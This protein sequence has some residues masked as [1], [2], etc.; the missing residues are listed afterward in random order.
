MPDTEYPMEIVAEFTTNH[1]GHTG[2]LMNMVHE[3]KKAGATRIKLQFKNVETYYTEHKLNSPIRSPF[4]DTYKEHRS[5]FELSDYQVDLVK[6]VCSELDLPV[7]AT[8]Q[9][10]FSLKRY[11]RLFPD[12]DWVKISSSGARDQHLIIPVAQAFP[13][14]EHTIVMSVAGLSLKNVEAHTKILR[15]HSKARLFIQHCVA[16]YPTPDNLSCVHNMA[17][18]ALALKD[19][20][21]VYV[22]FSSHETRHNECQRAVRMGAAIIERHFRIGSEFARS[23]AHHLDCADSPTSFNLLVQRIR[24]QEKRRPDFLSDPDLRAAYLNG[25]VVGD[26][27][28]FWLPQEQHKFLEDQFDNHVYT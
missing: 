7:F 12:A 6:A 16:V 13:K 9:D 4:G 26:G 3:A 1:F 8:V 22:G 28:N 21:N 27:T 23:P 15:E 25:F 2:L 18:I 10:V 19:M 11:Q 24:E 17:H 14:E 20:P 5:M